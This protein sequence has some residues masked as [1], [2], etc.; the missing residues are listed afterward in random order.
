[1]VEE[2][3]NDPLPVTN[4]A[5]VLRLARKFGDAEQFWRNSGRRTGGYLR[6]RDVL[7]STQ[8]L[9]RAA[10]SFER[11]IADYPD[12]VDAWRCCGMPPA[13]GVIM[14]PRQTR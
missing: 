5:F 2:Y 4:L 13:T 3:P 1:V 11:F 8:R 7:V 6:T 14:S 12:D 9:R 10:E